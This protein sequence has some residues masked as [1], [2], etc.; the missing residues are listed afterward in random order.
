MTRQ[1]SHGTAPVPARE[2]APL[3]RWPQRRGGAA[4]R[5][6]AR[7]R[8][9][10]PAPTRWRGS[11]AVSNVPDTASASVITDCATMAAVGRAKR[12]CTAARRA[13][14]ERRRGRTRRACAA[15]TASSR[16]GTR[17]SRPPRRPGAAARAQPP[18]EAPAA[19]ASGDTVASRARSPRT[20]CETICSSDV[21]HG[22][23]DHRQGDGAR[24]GPRRVADF[25]ARDQRHLDPGEREDQQQRGAR[26]VGGGRRARSRPGSRGRRRTGRR[27]PAAASG[28]SLATVAT[29]FRRDPSCT[30]RTLISRPEDQRR[31]QHQHLARAPAAAPA[32][33]GRRSPRTPSRRRPPRT[34]RS[35]RAARPETKPAYGPNAVPT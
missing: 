20:P 35:S 30:P 28:S 19:S 23:A 24:H 4:A 13:R 29:E 11:P 31:R 25:A 3:R 8:S 7:T 6:R 1:A 33:A 32:P 10:A 22:D 5:P 26:D 34:S 2:P 27:S 17:T 18:S 16:R 9:R 15:S 21:E 12:G 14:Q